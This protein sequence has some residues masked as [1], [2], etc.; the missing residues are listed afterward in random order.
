MQ[1]RL[2]LGTISVWGQLRPKLRSTWLQ[3]GGHGR[4]NMKSSTHPFSLVFPTFILGIDDA[5]CWA[6]FPMLCRC[7]AHTGANK[8]VPSCATLDA[9]ASHG[10]NPPQPRLTDH[11]GPTWRSWAPL[12]AAQA[13][14]GPN[15]RLSRL[16]AKCECYFWPSLALMGVRARPCCPHWSCLVPNFRGRCPHTGLSC[17]C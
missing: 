5:S 1:H 7:S 17:A 6:M 11:L 10:F 3:H 13:Q 9:C 4:P 16:N 2:Q 12:G 15:P 8:S 14:A